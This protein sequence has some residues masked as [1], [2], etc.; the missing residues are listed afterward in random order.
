M[1]SSSCGD[2]ERDAAAESTAEQKVNKKQANSNQEEA[3]VAAAPSDPQKVKQE[4]R[5]TKE[6]RRE[7]RS[8]EEVHKRKPAVAATS[9]AQTV[10]DGTARRGRDAQRKDLSSGDGSSSGSTSESCSSDHSCRVREWVSSP[11]PTYIQHE[12][13]TE[14]PTV[15]RH[16]GERRSG[17]HGKD[18]KRRKVILKGKEKAA[19]RTK[20]SA[21]MVSSGGEG[22]AVHMSYRK[23]GKDNS[24][25]K[26]RE[27]LSR[28]PLAHLSLHRPLAVP[29][30]LPAAAKHEA[31]VAAMQG[32][33]I[34]H[35][36][37]IFLNEH[38]HHVVVATLQ[39]GTPG[40]PPSM[41]PWRTLCFLR[42]PPWTIW[43]NCSFLR[44][45]T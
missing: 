20:G 3:A 7:K 15:R 38:P 30:H 16:R 21:G 5:S 37:P 24:R 41:S 19:P 33:S 13:W 42:M 44:L 25:R 28:R 26:S 2:C 34:P 43:Q 22:N 36:L 4:E 32:A 10:I 14:E 11:S 1:V 35:P 18:D 17:G 45:P 29:T 6:A 8:G 12:H 40:N 23:R 9:Q 39:G 31:E 27:P